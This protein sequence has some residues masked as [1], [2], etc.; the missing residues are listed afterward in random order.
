MFWNSIWLFN[1]DCLC[2]IINHDSFLI[3]LFVAFSRFK[4]IQRR[5]G[6]VNESQS[7]LSS[8]RWGAREWRISCGVPRAPNVANGAESVGLWQISFSND[9]HRDRYSGCL[10][11]WFTTKWRDHRENSSHANRIEIRKYLLCKWSLTPLWFCNGLTKSFHM[12]QYVTNTGSKAIFRTDKNAPNFRL[13][14]IDLN[15]Y[16]EENWT[17]LVPVSKQSFPFKFFTT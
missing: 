3:H 14:S 8:S 9:R 7:L 4:W 1:I 13:I 16:A 10:F 2:W 6:D 12:P 5:I 15:N 11:R 17:T